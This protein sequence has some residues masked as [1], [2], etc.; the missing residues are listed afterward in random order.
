MKA[1][2]NLKGDRQNYAPSINANILAPNFK[3]PGYGW[4]CFTLIGI[5]PGEGINRRLLPVG[6]GYDC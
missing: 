4:R 3:A 6:I 5:S 2:D 1:G